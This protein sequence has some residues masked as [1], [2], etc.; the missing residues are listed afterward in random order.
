[1]H[2]P[3]TGVS[4]MVRDRSGQST[5][6]LGEVGAVLGQGGRNS[7]TG[8]AEVTHEWDTEGFPVGGAR[9]DSGAAGGLGRHRRGG[10]SSK[11]T[12][13]GSGLVGSVPADAL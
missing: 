12:S 6:C 13:G 9:G 1:M 4:G 7:I 8:Q 2:L 11:G 5:G 10:R 3:G